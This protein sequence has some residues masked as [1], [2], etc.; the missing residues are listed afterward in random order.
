MRKTLIYLFALLLVV[1]LVI[2]TVLSVPKLRS[3]AYRAFPELVEYGFR[4]K[5]RYF[6]QNRLFGPA[7]S[8]LLSQ[9]NFVEWFSSQRNI[10]LPGLVANADYVVER[11]RDERDYS[12]L[13]PFLKRL[14]AAN[15]K[16]LP[17]HLWVAR[18]H[19]LENPDLTFKHLLVAK[20]IAPAE[21]RIYRIA[22]ETALLHNLSEK[23]LEWCQRYNQAQQF[24]GPHPYEY[25]PM[26]RGVGE[27]K[28]AIDTFF[29]DG[30]HQLIEN[31]G[32]QLD[33]E[34]VYSF[35][36]NPGEVHRL[37]IH[38]AIGAG[39]Q[40][41]FGNFEV[42]LGGV[43]RT[44]PSSAL[45]ISSWSSFV[46]RKGLIYTSSPDGATITIHTPP[47]IFGEVDRIDIRMRVKR[48]PSVSPDVCAIG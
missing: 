45:T 5:L 20:K 17:A 36:L 38:L 21:G 29:K 9:I 8:I 14:V 33:K 34:A 40:I 11:I 39:Y 42:Y 32:L 41:E 2:G 18:A 6:V 27:R 31:F 12:K 47:E 4:G 37:R 43:K 44:I 16:L 46:P 28:I 15:P 3:S 48:L 30:R 19:V 13:T 7:N 24:G 26:F 35:N 23:K 22:L 1:L 10:L 25:E